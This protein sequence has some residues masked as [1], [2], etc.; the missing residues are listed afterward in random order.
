MALAR[1]AC[2]RGGSLELRTSLWHAPE[3]LKQVTADARQQ[4][5]ILKSGIIQKTIDTF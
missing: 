3:F 2:E 4:M 5:I 1:V